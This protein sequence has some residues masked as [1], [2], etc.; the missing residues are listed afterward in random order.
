MRSYFHLYSNF[1]RCSLSFLLICIWVCH[2]FWRKKNSDRGGSVLF[3]KTFSY[4]S[5]SY[6][7]VTSF[8][9]PLVLSKFPQSHGHFHP[10]EGKYWFI[11]IFKCTFN[12]F[13]K[14]NVVFMKLYMQQRHS[15]EFYGSTTCLKT[16]ITTGLDKK[17]KDSSCEPGVS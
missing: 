14:L 11:N 5:N 9:L 15:K 4:V 8:F 6:F 16:F 1:C 10:Q 12:F 17:V 2:T 7:S 13:K 3:W